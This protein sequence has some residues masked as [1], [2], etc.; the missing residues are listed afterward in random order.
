MNLKINVSLF[1]LFF[2]LFLFHCGNKDSSRN[3]KDFYY[4]ME[5]L[6]DG[7]VY[8]YR[9]VNN[10]SLPEEYWYFRTLETD[11]ATYF[12]G[13][14]IDHFFNIRQLS[15]E[16]VV[17]NGTLIHDYIL[18]EVDSAGFANNLP[19]EIIVPN[20]FPFKV[21][22]STGVFLTELKWIY[23]KEPEIST[24]LVRNRRYKGD[25]TYPYQGVERACIKF[26][27]IELVDNF[28]EGHFQAEFRGTEL[29][30]KGIG[31]IYYKKDIGDELHLEYELKEMY[32]MEKLEEKLKA[33]QSQ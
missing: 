13:E 6:K 2:C 8:E 12:I 31:L 7:M 28:E 25:A 22:D 10:D 1:L 3:I 32:S 26:D 21:T 17:S 30:A 14:Y 18:F 5:N 27:L 19:A 24:T 4:P 16:E 11:T 33:F 23:Q 20:A 29:Y 15:S 9:G